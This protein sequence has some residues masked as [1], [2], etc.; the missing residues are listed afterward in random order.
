M[1]HGWRSLVILVGIFLAGRAAAPCGAAL[2]DETPAGPATPTPAGEPTAPA[3]SPP[4]EKYKLAYKFLPNQVMRYEVFNET[5]IRTTVKDETETVRN[6]SESKRHY[7][8]KA[9]DENSGEGDLELSIDWVHMVA[10]FENP[11][12]AKTEPIEF[13]SDDPEKHPKQ[14]DDVQATVGKP[15]AT[16]RFS[17]AGKVVKVL[18]GAVPPPPSAARQLAQGPAAPPGADASPESYFVPLPEEPVAVGAT[19]KDRVDVLLRD[20]KR[21]L[22]KITIQQNYR[23]TEVKE[24]R[25]T[26]ELRTVV[27]TPVNNP[28]I[29]GQL[30]QR[31]I[32]GHLVFDIERGVVLSRESGVD[33][34]VI[35]AFGAKSSMHARSKYREKLVE[36][37]AAA[38]RSGSETIEPAGLPE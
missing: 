6:S 7:T 13:Q 18:K 38:S 28:A 19:W 11:A 8:V 15:R 10:S 33:N 37:Q 30:I 36:D 12:R 9:V 1:L 32:S 22:Q 16:I 29:Q 5:E 3:E 21:N 25:A 31:E 26:I 35:G 14:F 34:T 27:L 23:L 2:A 17:P 20:E 24:K 4:S